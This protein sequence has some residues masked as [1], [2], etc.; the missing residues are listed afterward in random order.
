MWGMFG[1]AY[2]KPADLDSLV[3]SQTQ[4]TLY[5]IP[6]QQHVQKENTL[7]LESAP[8]VPCFQHEVR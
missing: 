3:R 5:S 1:A 8:V 6:Q 4:S 7:E 2:L